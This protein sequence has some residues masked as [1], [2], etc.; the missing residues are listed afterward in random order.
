MREWSIR[1]SPKNFP[2]KTTR[3]RVETTIPWAFMKVSQTKRS[4]KLRLWCRDSTLKITMTT[5]QP[6]NRTKSTSKRG[7]TWT[8]GSKD[9]PVT[10]AHRVGITDLSLAIPSSPGRARTHLLLG[11]WAWSRKVTSRERRSGVCSTNTGM[12]E[13]LLWMQTKESWALTTHRTSISTRKPPNLTQ[14]WG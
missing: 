12:A 9:R 13:P 5:F 14:K 7:T 11:L 6:Q 10:L 8:R 3:T 1:W 2:T 4:K